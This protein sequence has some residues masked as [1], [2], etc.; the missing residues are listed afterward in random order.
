MGRQ[1]SMY[2]VNEPH[3]N[4]KA[5]PSTWASHRLF[6]RSFASGGGAPSAMNPLGILKTHDLPNK[7]I[8]TSPPRVQM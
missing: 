4:S 5:L 1:P 6:G 3:P 7:H 8:R 2:N